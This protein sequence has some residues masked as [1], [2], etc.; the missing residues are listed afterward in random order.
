LPKWGC[1]EQGCIYSA[2]PLGHRAVLRG[3]R[4]GLG[5]KGRS[6]SNNTEKNVGGK[7]GQKAHGGKKGERPMSSRKKR[8]REGEGGTAREVAGKGLEKGKTNHRRLGGKGVEASSCKPT[9]K[10]RKNAAR[11][12]NEDT[13]PGKK[14]T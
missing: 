1:H 3:S 9:Q 13:G 14:G 12:G 5:V 8:E 6:Q 7:N 4:Y 10:A 11:G 2:G